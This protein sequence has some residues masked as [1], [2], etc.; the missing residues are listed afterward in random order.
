MDFLTILQSSRLQITSSLPSNFAPKI[1]EVTRLFERFLDRL[2]RSPI[3]V[4]KHA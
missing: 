1:D 2:V 3:L 4:A